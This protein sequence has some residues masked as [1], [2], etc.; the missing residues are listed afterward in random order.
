MKFATLK[1]NRSNKRGHAT[2]GD[3]I[4]SL[5]AEQFLPR[6]DKRF[7]REYLRSVSENEK[8]L[9]IMNGWFCLYPA[10]S[11]PPSESIEPVFIGFHINRSTRY[12][13]SPQCIEYFKKHEPI[14]CR[15]R[16]TTQLLASKGVHSFQSKC[17][18]LTFPKRDKEPS[19][20]KVF[21]VDAEN[22]PIP[23]H[24]YEE[25][26]HITHITQNFWGDEIKTLMAKK[27][28]ALYRDEA[29]LVITTKLHC[30]LPCIALGVPVV[31]FGRSSEAR[32]SL[33]KDLNVKIYRAPNGLTG[34]SYKKISKV[35]KNSPWGK[36][37]RRLS[38]LMFTIFTGKVDWNPSPIDIE[39]EKQSLIKTTEDLVKQKLH[40][41]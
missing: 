15:D 31:F 16:R 11:F 38:G 32:I 18:T 41:A 34:A 2:L 39:Q 28:L 6:V 17:L 33:L 7:E 25:A 29:R 5:A 27:L 13:L 40:V 4:M 36:I 1:Y 8:H 22:I 30:A 26:I 19:N 3:E 24:I 10:D 35:L 23:E 12:F 21:L 20:G 9:L 14:G 37:F